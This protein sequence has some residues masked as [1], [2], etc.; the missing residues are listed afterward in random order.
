MKKSLFALALLG[1]SA[2]AVTTIS[3]QD[4]PQVPGVVD[5]SR[6]QAG[7][8]ALDPSHTL[9]SWRVHHFGFNDYIGLFGDIT[10][11]MEL[12]PANVEAASFEI[13]IPIAKAT[14]ASEG[15]REHFFRPGKDGASPDFFGP[16]PEPAKFTSTSIRQTGETTAVISGMLTMNGKS[17]PVTMLA[18]FTGAGANPFSDAE[19]IGFEARAVID[20]REWD[21][22]YAVPLVGEK[23]EL[24]ITAAFELQ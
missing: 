4:A 21:I 14:V 19:T 5:V 3:A 11:Q 18:E 7:S 15:L 6:V 9:V 17:A 23:V 20:R 24:E 10:G 22:N 16:D 1:S 2:F 12:D 8:Y 13:E